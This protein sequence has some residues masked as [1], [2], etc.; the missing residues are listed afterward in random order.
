MSFFTDVKIIVITALKVFKSEG[1]VEG[2]KVSKNE[3]IS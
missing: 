1:I 2:E 3:N